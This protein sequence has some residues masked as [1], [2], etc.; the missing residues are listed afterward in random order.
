MSKGILGNPFFRFLLTAVLLYLV[1]YSVYE[2]Y[3]KPDS[4][5]DEWI[6]HQIVMMS[7][8][9][10]ELIGFELVPYV[11]APLYRDQLAIEGSIG[12]VVGAPCDGIV[13]FG[14]FIVFV[15]SFPGPWKHKLWFI[16]A[17]LI[18]IH[19]INVLRVAALAIIVHWNEEWMAFNHDYTFTII[20][21]AFVF[22]LWY[23]WV[24]RF[25]PLSKKSKSVS[26]EDPH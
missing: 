15:L 19:L 22:F 25:S 20:V 9:F 1:W 14:L 16:P 26:V 5:L 18:A 8:G 10:L 24:N 11:D 21:Y 7:R 13:L 17:G 6:I 12:V 4:A 3:I 2:Y 23:I